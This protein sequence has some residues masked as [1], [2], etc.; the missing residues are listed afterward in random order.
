MVMTITCK[1]A[2]FSIR[3][4]ENQRHL[5]CSTFTI[6]P[7]DSHILPG[8]VVASRVGA[9]KIHHG[10]KHNVAPESKFSESKDEH[11]DANQK[12]LPWPRLEQLEKQNK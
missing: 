1:E 5:V 7:K 9:E 8:E 2:E 3:L 12:V 10:L 11:T 4:E 6:T